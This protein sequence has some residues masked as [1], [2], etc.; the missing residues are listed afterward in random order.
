MR[1]DKFHSTTATPGLYYGRKW[2][3]WPVWCSWPG[4]ASSQWYQLI[5]SILVLRYTFSRSVYR[6]YLREKFYYSWINIRVLIIGIFSGGVTEQYVF[7]SALRSWAM[8]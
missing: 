3:V 4:T 2:Y 6:G 8:S 1:L 5:L 7:P